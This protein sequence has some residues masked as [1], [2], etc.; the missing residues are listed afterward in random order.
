MLGKKIKIRNCVVCDT[1]NICSTLLINILL[2][3]NIIYV[4][5]YYVAN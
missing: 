2:D 3:M 1:M 4:I 5:L